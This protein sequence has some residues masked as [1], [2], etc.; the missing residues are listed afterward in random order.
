V[1][2]KPI[3]HSAGAPGRAPATIVDVAAETAR[4]TGTA[5]EA[6]RP[7]RDVRGARFG[8]R[9]EAVGRARA[10]V[11]ETLAG[12]D[13]PGPRGGQGVV[14]D[15]VLLVS[16]LVTNAILHAGT[17]ADV[18]CVR[19]RDPA[20]VPEAVRVE[21]VD[22][23]P[24]R[25]IPTPH[26]I[27][28]GGPQDGPDLPEGGRG[29]Y[30]SAHIA[31]AWGVQYS[32]S[33]KQIWFTLDF[34]AHP[35]REPDGAPAVP[36]APVGAGPRSTA[37]EQD[38]AAH[39]LDDLDGYLRLAAERAKALLQADGA[40]VL[41]ADDGGL[42]AGLRLRAEA[43]LPPGLP[44]HSAAPSAAHRIGP[45]GMPSVYTDLAGP[46]DHGSPLIAAL[47][48]AGLRSMATAPLVSAGR[49]HGLIGAVARAPGRF[50]DAEAVLLGEYA[51]RIGV[52]VETARLAEAGRARRGA[53]A[54][55]AEAGELL[56]GS[57]DPERCLALAAQLVVPG[58]ARWCAVHT[59][60]ATGRPRL[61]LVWHADERL[62]DA[63]HAAVA[64][65]GAPPAEAV[66]DTWPDPGLRD[67][68]VAPGELLL[69]PLEA[70]GQRL[71][72][73]TLATAPGARFAQNTEELAR[74]L[75]RR[76]AITYDSA[77]AYAGRRK[78]AHD[79]QSSLLPARIPQVPGADIA[80]VYHPAGSA[81]QR[82]D[83]TADALV[84]GDFYDVF[85]IRPGCWGLAIGDVCGT[86]PQAAAVTGLARHA[87]RLLAREGLRPPAVLARLNQAILDEGERGRFLTLLYGEA[88]VL[89]DGSLSLALVCAGHPAPL[90]LRADGS[91]LPGATNQP[92]L[93]VI[94]G[95]PDFHLDSLLLR[96]GETMLAF[97]DGASE[98]R[99]GPV[100]ME[101]EGLAAVLAECRG[102][103][104]GGTAG[105]VQRAVEDFG[106]EPLGD[107]MAILVL[108]AAGRS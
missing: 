23:H 67:P 22:R 79:L 72:T 30:L 69:I 31:D 34:A 20:G 71:G 101:A 70:R 17:A 85:E 16:E 96:P 78:T 80:V 68:A 49:L 97:T 3:T 12:W 98:R 102:L 37:A 10:F 92:L 87:L 18:V 32:R 14:D 94:D 74:D 19:L 29:L 83:V 58:L 35:A 28:G 95:D 63:A 57:L 25:P 106:D 108:R 42:E 60:D 73:L 90:V 107:D 105:R 62:Y 59:R 7:S 84:G 40:F 88:E 13:L 55:L 66:P 104:A 91:V 89:A 26:R 24:G 45:A 1:W 103:T 47:G 99:R 81:G 43:G 76:V 39:A 15:A 9:P 75:G 33:A 100:M 46:A 61:A 77:L 36:G 65:S 27:R 93:G 5:R 82:A 54:F 53:L 44:R 38:E 6:A 4:K 41:L 2:G 11:R 48:E 51:D 64:G 56:A 86:G 8:P 50:T 21:V 52:V